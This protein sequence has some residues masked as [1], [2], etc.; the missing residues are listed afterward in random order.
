MCGMD[1]ILLG[2]ISPSNWS[3][4]GLLRILSTNGGLASYRLIVILSAVDQVWHRI[5]RRESSQRVLGDEL[6]NQNVM[7]SVKRRRHTSL[8]CTNGRGLDLCPVAPRTYRGLW[9]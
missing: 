3:R 8:V 4:A 2:V 6:A 7:I 9:R 5:K 1:G